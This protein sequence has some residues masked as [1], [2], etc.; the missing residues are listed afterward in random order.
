MG[1]KAFTLDEKQI[2]QLEIMAGFMTISEIAD[3]FGMCEKTLHN[4]KNR[5]DDINT[6]YKRGRVKL[7]AKAGSVLIEKALAGNTAELF[8]LLKTQFGFRE[9]QQIDHTTNGKDI[10]AGLGYFYG[11]SDETTESDT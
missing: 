3:Y 7:K 2:A 11:E 4:I 1:R 5:D 6:V 9:T 10:K 8:F